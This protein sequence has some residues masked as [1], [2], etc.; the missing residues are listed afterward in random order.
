MNNISAT[1]GW[2][3]EVILDTFNGSKRCT[4]VEKVTTRHKKL[5]Q[6]EIYT[7]GK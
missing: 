3:S 6:L 5:I 7:T 4:K 2:I 1:V